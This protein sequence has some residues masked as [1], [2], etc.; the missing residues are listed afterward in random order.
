MFDDD[1]N[2]LPRPPLRIGDDL[3][4]ISIDELEQRITMLET[5]IARLRGEIDAKKAT[6]AAANDIF[7]A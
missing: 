6:K 7:K 2:R 3:S 4:A 5:E 1:V